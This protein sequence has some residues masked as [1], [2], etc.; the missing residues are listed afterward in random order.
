MAEA[1]ASPGA[2]APTRLFIVETTPAPDALL[3][4]LSIC[5]ARQIAP[6][7]V[8]YA[9]APEGGAIRI[10][11]EGLGGDEAERLSARLQAAPA[12]RGVSLGWRAAPI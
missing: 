1:V 4:V 12:V 8:A 2:S 10:E 3:L 6:T 5:A 9:A 7:A 11:V